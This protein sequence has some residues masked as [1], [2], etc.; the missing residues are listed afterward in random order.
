MGN[1]NWT[2]YIYHSYDQIP[3]QILGVLRKGLLWVIL[4]EHKPALVGKS[5]LWVILHEA[6]VQY[7]RSG[8]T[9]VHTAPIDRKQREKIVLFCGV[10]HF[11]SFRNTVR[12]TMLSAVTVSI[13]LYSIKNRISS[14]VCPQICLSGDPNSYQVVNVHWQSQI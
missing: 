6:T 2:N 9:A 14:L 8:E 7:S 4:H 3:N 5:L 10:C 12:E 1:N 11:S 13:L